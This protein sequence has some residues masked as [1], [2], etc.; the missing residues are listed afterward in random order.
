[1]YTE[2]GEIENSSW[3]HSLEEEKTE[4]KTLLYIICKIEVQ[5]PVMIF[6]SVYD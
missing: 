2:I 4:K 6:W 5:V 3:T 1:M